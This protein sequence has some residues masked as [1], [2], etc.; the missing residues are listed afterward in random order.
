VQ[1]PE[2][3]VLGG[4]S[5]KGKSV[6]SK[7]VWV[8]AADTRTWSVVRK[9]FPVPPLL[10][11]PILQGEEEITKRGDADGVWTRRTTKEGENDEAK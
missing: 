5:G 3:E 8:G 7:N 9:G 6:P 4:R 2:E 10:L 11:P 1:R